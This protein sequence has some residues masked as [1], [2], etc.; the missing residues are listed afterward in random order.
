MEEDWYADR[1]RLRQLLQA[2]PG[3]SHRACAAEIGRSLGWIKKWTKRLRAAAP[4]DDCV[5]RGQSRARKH[6]PPPWDA[7]VIARIL[8]IRD[9]PP[10][11]LRRTPGP[12]AILYYL[13]R[14]AD[15]PALGVLLPRSTRTVW[16]I[17]SQ[18]GRILRPARPTHEPVDRPAPLTSWQLD[19]KDAATVAA[20]P[21][22]KRQ[23]SVEVL[24]TVDV[25]TS[26]L[27]DAQAE[28][29]FTAQTSVV[30]VAQLV[31]AHGLPERVTFDRDTR[32]V[33]SWSSR[34]FPAPFVRLWS[35]LGVEVTICPPHR[36]DKNAF[37]ERYH[38]SYN[39]ECL[40]V[41]R[42]GTLAEVR[43]VTASYQEHYNW[44]RPN[45]AVSCGNLPPRV[46]FPALPARPAV[47]FIVDPDAW[48]RTV[49]GR[50]YV[51][52]VRENGTV[53]VNDTPYYVGQSLAGQYV[54][55]QV[56]APSREFAVLHQ[57]QE[58]KRL[59]I[60]GL[61]GQPLPFDTFVTAMAEQARTERGARPVAAC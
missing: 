54:G 6:P 7:R 12:K 21:E 45:Q 46:A 59:P 15:L 19:F 24:N 16:R 28:E 42:P 29:D 48:L 27:L 37:V 36:P 9:Q 32:F 20:V 50:S 43:S 60:K 41:E 39:S 30:A 3:W 5:L 53:L 13:Q 33:G 11:H 38:R 17:L 2:H 34:D 14:D 22:G 56:D 31:R 35:C 25:G 18:N 44:E 61:L 23:H 26:L 10:E 52:K 49:D 57:G 55:V 1:I 58:I 8:E 40:Q 51:R 4:D 47:P